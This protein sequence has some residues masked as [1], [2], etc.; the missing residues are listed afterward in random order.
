MNDSKFLHALF[1]DEME[2]QTGREDLQPTDYIEAFGGLFRIYTQPLEN[3]QHDSLHLLGILKKPIEW[4]FVSTCNELERFKAQLCLS[5]QW[6]GRDL[7][8]SS[9][10]E[11]IH[12]QEDISTSLNK[13]YSNLFQQLD[14]LEEEGCTYGGITDLRIKI[15]KYE[16]L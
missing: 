16:M 7:T 3:F 8:V 13:A 4:L 5:V 12:K 2:R 10:F 15:C 9:S 14:D 6:E 11:P 1:L